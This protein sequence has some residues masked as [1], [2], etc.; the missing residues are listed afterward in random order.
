MHTCLS[1]CGDLDMHPSAIVEQALRTGLDIIAISDHN[2]SENVGYVI[3]AA[4]GK[5]LTVIPGMEVTTREEV[6]VLALFDDLSRLYELQETVYAQL[7]GLNNEEVFGLQPIVTEEGD[8]EGFNERLLIGATKVSLE[9][10][11][12]RIHGLGGIAIS[13]HI[14]RPAFGIIG[15]L[16][17]VPPNV[18]FDALEI[19][20]RMGIKGGRERFP[21]LAGYPFL[22]SSDAH[23][24]DDMGKAC[25]A[26]MLEGPSLSEIRMALRREGGR[27]VLEDAC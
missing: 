1:P 5:P 4:S 7:E 20:W 23:F 8:V 13:A 3:K 12:A 9:D 11:V 15:Q 19:S 18:P 25:T 21:E 27:H 22:T 17:F 16:G 14:D 2:S 26:M 24:I 10:L 6:H